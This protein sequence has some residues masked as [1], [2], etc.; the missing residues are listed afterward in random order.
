MLFLLT[1]NFGRHSAVASLL[2]LLFLLSLLRNEELWRL[3]NQM[4]DMRGSVD[5]MGD[6]CGQ[7][8]NRFSTDFQQIS[9]GARNVTVSKPPSQE[10]NDG[11]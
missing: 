2:L 1:G 8:F 9:T 7:I 11:T 3:Q 4:K 5:V 6:G 10:K